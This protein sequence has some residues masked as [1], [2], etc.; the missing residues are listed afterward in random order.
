MHHARVHEHAMQVCAVGSSFLLL[1]MTSSGAVSTVSLTLSL[2]LCSGAL[3]ALL[4]S[5]PSRSL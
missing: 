2:V 4:A 1:S 5:C 3:G